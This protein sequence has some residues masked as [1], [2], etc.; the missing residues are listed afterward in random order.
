M[1]SECL[2][3]CRRAAPVLQGRHRAHTHVHTYTIIHIFALVER[4]PPHARAHA[5][6]HTTHARTHARSHEH[7]KA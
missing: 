1:F 6:T 3:R 4:A 2:P 5:R 7:I